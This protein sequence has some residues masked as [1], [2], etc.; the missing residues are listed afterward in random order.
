[1]E[2]SNQNTALLVMD[3]QEATMKLLQENDTFIRSITKAIATARSRAIPVLYVVVGFRKG[4]P[5]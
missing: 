4:Y 3:V 2:P 5:K 1:M